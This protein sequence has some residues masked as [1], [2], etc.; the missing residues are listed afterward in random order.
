M[1]FGRIQWEGW[2]DGERGAERPIDGSSIHAT[3]H[4]TG[5]PR[6]VAER[7]LNRH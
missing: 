5:K 6:R 3:V 7:R 2:A 4:G 1:S